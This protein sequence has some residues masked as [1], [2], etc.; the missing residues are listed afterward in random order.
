[1][2]GLQPRQ[3]DEGG[4]E[5]GRVVKVC[6]GAALLGLVNE[7]NVLLRTRSINQLGPG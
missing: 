1:M 3:G 5:G 6:E 7:M 4:E 2:E